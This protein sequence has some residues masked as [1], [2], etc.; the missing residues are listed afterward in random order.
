MEVYSLK[1]VTKLNKSKY[2]VK[3]K[4]CPKFGQVE[5]AKCFITGNQLAIVA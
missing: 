1:K 5:V 3:K 2:S 4:C